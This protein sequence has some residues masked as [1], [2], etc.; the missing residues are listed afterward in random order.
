MCKE[1]AG[2]AGAIQAIAAAM[3]RNLDNASVQEDGCHALR[4]VVFH[5][6]PNLQFVREQGGIEAVVNA[7]KQHPQ[8]EAVQ[9]EGCWALVVCCSNHGT[10][11]YIRLWVQS[12]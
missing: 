7:M 11:G 9:A 12:G 6:E 5:C 1:T 3:A 10:R 2:E 4:N 8:N